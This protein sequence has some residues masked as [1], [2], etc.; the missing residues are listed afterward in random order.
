MGIASSE[1][2]GDAVYS[3]KSSIV[4]ITPY[5]LS[6][7]NFITASGFMRMFPPGVRLAESSF[8]LIQ[9]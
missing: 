8:F 1:F 7:S 6:S 9:I 3:V 5:N 4:L 2:R